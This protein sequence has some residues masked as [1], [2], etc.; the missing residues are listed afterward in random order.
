MGFLV[1]PAPD[2]RDV[3][4]VPPST[5][6]TTI[7]FPET[8]SGPNVPSGPWTNPRLPPNLVPIHYQVTLQP[9]LEPDSTG[10]YWFSGNSK[11]TFNVTESTDVIVIHAYQLNITGVGLHD[12]EV[13]L[14]SL[15]TIFFDLF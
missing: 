11:V 3:I 6:T 12:S 7:S 10:R 9:L 14:Y 2:C 4:T 8:T 5:D 1:N 15:S 13:C